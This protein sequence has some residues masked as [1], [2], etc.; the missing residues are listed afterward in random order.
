M[1]EFFAHPAVPLWTHMLLLVMYVVLGYAWG[2]GHEKRVQRAHEA[3]VERLKRRSARRHAKTAQ[4]R[5]DALEAKLAG[6]RLARHSIP[7]LVT[8]MESQELAV[9]AQI[10]AL[11]GET[12]KPTHITPVPPKEGFVV[13]GEYRGPDDV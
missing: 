12:V 9:E 3:R 6:I 11:E 8:Q 10:L 5:R 7:E 4:G 1:I 13:Q 2:A